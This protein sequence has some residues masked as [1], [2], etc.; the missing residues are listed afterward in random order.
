MTIEPDRQSPAAEEHLRAGVVVR[1]VV[2]ADMPA[3]AEIYAH[4]VLT[5]TGSFEEEPP[6]PTAD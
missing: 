3:V 4:H 2:A 6:D 1:P 5:G